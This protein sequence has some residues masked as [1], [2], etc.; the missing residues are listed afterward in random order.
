[1]T[2]TINYLTMGF[3]LLESKDIVAAGAANIALYDQRLALRW[4]YENIASFGDLQ[5][6]TRTKPPQLLSANFGT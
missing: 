3:G 4:I 2:V 1:M 5:S 6:L